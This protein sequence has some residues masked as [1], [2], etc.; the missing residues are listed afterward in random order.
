[1]SVDIRQFYLF[2]TL[3]DEAHACFLEG[4]RTR[5]LQDGELVYD[6]GDEPDFVFVVLQGAVRL[7]VPLPDGES[8]FLGVVPAST[9]LGEH[10][11]LCDTYSVARVSAVGDL[12]LLAIPKGN[13]LHVFKTE[14]AFTQTLTQQLAMTMRMLCL[15]AAH[16]FT[17]RVDKKLASILIHLA[18]TI[19]EKQPESVRLKVK[20]SQDELAQMIS[21]SRQTVNKHLQTWRKQGWIGMDQGRIELFQM[22]KLKDLSSEQVMQ[23]LRSRFNSQRP[24]GP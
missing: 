18:E 17:S 19:G 23:E 13:F 6:V 2:S 16:H 12:T 8:L 21:A 11:A 20:L 24:K 14:P 5:C 15:A 10:E 3:S 9:L 7:E 1:M 22:A 4:S